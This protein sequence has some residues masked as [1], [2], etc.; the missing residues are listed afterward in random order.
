MIFDFSEYELSNISYGGSE[1]KLGILIKNEPYMLKFQKKTPF[2]LRFNHISEY[3]G[4]HIYELLGLKCQ[5]TYLGYYNN[6]QV[7]ACK[8]FV[9][10]GFQFVPFN[11]VG[12]S[13]IESNK[14]KYQYSY[15]DIII[16][17]AFIGNFDRHGANWGFLKRNNKYII[18]PVFDNGS[19]LFP[20]LTNEDEMIFILNNQDE[21]NKRI[22]K[23]PTSQI[24]L[25]G[26]KSSYF[27]IIS[28][29][30]YKECNEALT[31]IFPRINMNDI[32]NLIDNIELISQTHKQ[33]YK[34][35]LNERYEKIIKY[36]YNKLRGK[37]YE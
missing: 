5:K 19:C 21:L 31:R 29:L 9:A 15:S 22:F 10:E 25:N 4:C 26:R 24:K 18:A 14:E 13:T 30:R 32:F 35:I 36:S 12:E 33:F 34:K 3:L 11:D 17:D 27:E 7:V 20:N 2:N 6:Q 8:D 23:F 16:I 37:S 28:S 1:K